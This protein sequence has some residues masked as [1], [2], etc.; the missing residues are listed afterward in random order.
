MQV[1][2]SACGSDRTDLVE[3]VPIEKLARGWAAVDC[4]GENSNY[5]SVHSYIYSASV[6]SVIYEPFSVRGAAAHLTALHGLASAWYE[7][8]W[9]RGLVTLG[10]LLRAGGAKYMRKITGIRLMVTAR[11]VTP[12]KGRARYPA[13]LGIGRTAV[14]HGQEMKGQL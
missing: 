9:R 7:K 2:C 3:T 14:V 12:P 8:R 6:E 11:R 10:W 1:N 5:E 4:H 13:H